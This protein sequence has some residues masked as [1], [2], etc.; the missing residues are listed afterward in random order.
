MLNQRLHVRAII[1]AAFV[2]VSLSAVVLARLFWAPTV[3]VNW[4]ATRQTIDGFGASATG[5]TGDL[6]AEQADRFFRADTGLG[7]SLLRIKAI[8]GTLDTDCSCVSNHSPYKC[9]VGPDSQI[10]T[11]DL[12]IAQL[13]TERDVRLFA[14]PWSPPATMKTSGKYCSSGSMIGNI[15]NYSR[16]AA[17]LASFPQ[18]LKA[19]GV[20]ID[21]LSIQN[22]PNVEDSQY[23]TCRWSAQQIHDFIPYLSDALRAADFQTV[24]IALP[25]ETSWRF[26]LM[27]TAMND[28][29]VAEKVGLLLGHAYGSERPSIVPSTHGLH[30]WQS[31]VGGFKSFDGSMSD[32]LTWA[33]FIHNYMTVGANAWMY[34][35]LDCGELYFN[36]ETNMCLTDH[37]SHFAKRAYVLGQYAKF[38]RP[39]WQRIDVINR[40]WLRVTAYKGPA[41]K[42]AV[43]VVN[44]GWLAARNQEIVLRGVAARRS[45]IVPWLTSA[46]VSLEAQTAVSTTA[47]GSKFRYSI[48]ARSVVTFQGQAD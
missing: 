40:G 15:E 22:E 2:C 1:F 20:S 33:T 23:D 28:P 5:Y 12:R 44:Q 21:A 42:F 10:L 35:N 17:E 9:V 19:H 7:L 26:D 47:D 32:A 16:Y 27:K 24:K 3:I 38:I 11:G 14:A 18:L 34:W 48:P 37:D 30:V 36:A 8:P 25:E 29:T 6:S 4:N 41:N 43:V 45:Q 46:S 13:A 39:G 31:E